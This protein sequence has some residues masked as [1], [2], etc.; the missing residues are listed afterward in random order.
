MDWSKVKNIQESL[1]RLKESNVTE[2]STVTMLLDKKEVH[3]LSM[4]TYGNGDVVIHLDQDEQENPYLQAL[5]EIDTH[6]RSTKD[7]LPYIIET[8]KK[9][10]PE[11]KE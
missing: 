5:R 11:H 10:L 2:D 3:F 8:L 7:P 6:I 9:T 1:N 4:G